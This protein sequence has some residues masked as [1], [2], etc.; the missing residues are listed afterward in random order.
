MTETNSIYSKLNVSLHFDEN[1]EFFNKYSPN[2]EVDPSECVNRILFILRL[3]QNWVN[4]QI[5]NQQQENMTIM[6]IYDI[7]DLELSDNYNINYFL[8][9]FRYITYH[10]RDCIRNI[11]EELLD[12]NQR[13]QLFFGSSLASSGGNDDSLSKSILIQ[14]L[15]DGLH[16]WIYHTVHVKLEQFIPNKE[17]ESD[18]DEI[19]DESKT[20]FLID[21]GVKA[22]GEYMKN[23]MSSS[24]RYRSN[25]SNNSRYNDQNVLNSKFMTTSYNDN[26]IQQ[27]QTTPNKEK[28]T[29]TGGKNDTLSALAIYQQQVYDNEQLMNKQKGSEHT[30]TAHVEERKGEDYPDVYDLDNSQSNSFID[31]VFEEIHRGG[32][33]DAGLLSKFELFLVSELYDSDAIEYDVSEIKRLKESSNI[34]SAVGHNGILTQILIRFCDKRASLGSIYDAGYRFFYWPYYKDI[35]AE[36]HTLSVHPGGYQYTEGNSG[37][38]IKHWYIPQKYKDLKYELLFNKIYQFTSDHF[39]DIL[40]KSIIKLESWKKDAQCR[41]LESWNTDFEKPWGIKYKQPISVQH[42]MSILFYTNFSKQSAAFSATFRRNSPFEADES[43]KSRNREYWHWSK[44]LREAIECFGKTM[45]DEY[46]AG[47]KML[48]HGVSSSLIFD[49]TFINICGPLSTTAGL[50]C[51]QFILV[52]KMKTN[53]GII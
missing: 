4:H 53:N 8:N 31:Y 34:L 32:K 44:L 10:N 5:Q 48:Y 23:K 21:E 28:Q 9:D 39:D 25:R 35:E 26:A 3:Y 47:L 42:I 51:F 7:I 18:D 33:I 22:F 16:E 49:S 37:Y 13:R 11:D 40:N 27:H 2:D 45:G 15:L 12:C 24:T 20:I 17:N 50:F 19:E 14:D 46:D 52:L 29:K 41:K 1:K 38:S 30:N 6:D 36:Y 43:L